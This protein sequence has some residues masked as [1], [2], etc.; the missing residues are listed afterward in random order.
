MSKIV[1]ARIDDRLIH[2]QVMTAWLQYTGGNHIVIVDDATAEDDF[3]KSVMEMSVPQSIGLDVF[4]IVDGIDYLRKDHGQDNILIL[5]KTPEAYLK[6]IEKGVKIEK[7]IVG[8]MGANATRSKFHK[9][10]SASKDEKETFRKIISNGT[11][12]KI[13]IVPTDKEIDAA[14]LLK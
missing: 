2:G 10:I 1:L 7:V 11:S 6:L 3:L 9:N 12:V 14:G 4:N 8:G 5:A 13:Q